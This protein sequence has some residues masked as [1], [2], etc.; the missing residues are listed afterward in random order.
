MVTF[1]RSCVPAVIQTKRPATIKW[2][3]RVQ[4]LWHGDLGMTFLDESGIIL[5]ISE[6]K[7]PKKKNTH[8]Q[9]LLLYGEVRYHET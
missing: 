8:E 1:L 3:L 6:K 7:K 4:G 5:K 2:G 9:G